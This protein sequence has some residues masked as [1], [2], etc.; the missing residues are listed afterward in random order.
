MTTDMGKG[1]VI[2]KRLKQMNHPYPVAIY[3]FKGDAAEFI[4]G[5]RLAGYTRQVQ[6]AP[7]GHG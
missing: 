1:Y 7:Q 3:D 5:L 4:K 6:F 2:G